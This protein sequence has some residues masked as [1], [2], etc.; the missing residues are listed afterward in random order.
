MGRIH[1][2]TLGSASTPSEGLPLAISHL[3]YEYSLLFWI[4]FNTLSEGL[5]LFFVISHLQYEYNVF[6]NNQI[7]DLAS[8]LQSVLYN[9]NLDINICLFK[10][11]GP[12]V[13]FIINRILSFFFKKKRFHQV[14]Y[15]IRNI[16][17]NIIFL[18][19][20]EILIHYL[21]LNKLLL[22]FLIMKK[23]Y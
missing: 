5:S 12:L 13:L 3:Q 20:K 19:H 15:T 22:R 10:T 11:L 6:I 18:N 17:Q 14:S 1:L 4:S 23:L 9:F 8:D 7:S 21:F 16:N 2:L